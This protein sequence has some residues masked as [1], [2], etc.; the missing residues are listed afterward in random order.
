MKTQNKPIQ[1]AY[2]LKVIDIV[3]EPWHWDDIVVYADSPGEAKSSGI[4]RFDG[5]EIKDYGHK[6]IFIL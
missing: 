6:G 1:K 2:H 5:A 4:S 3:D